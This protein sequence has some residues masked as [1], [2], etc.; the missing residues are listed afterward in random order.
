MTAGSAERGV[1]VLWCLA[2]H[3]TG[4]GLMVCDPPGVVVVRGPDLNAGSHSLFLY[5]SLKVVIHFGQELF[6][7]S[8]HRLILPNSSVICGRTFCL[9]GCGECLED[10]EKN[11]LFEPCDDLGLGA[12]TLAGEPSGDRSAAVSGRLR[13]VLGLRQIA[14]ERRSG[15]RHGPVSLLRE[16]SK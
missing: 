3:S 12:L 4:L 10:S 11:L 7:Q 8:I 15:D 9:I 6:F 14:S 2:N 13:L 5:T 1:V 16:V